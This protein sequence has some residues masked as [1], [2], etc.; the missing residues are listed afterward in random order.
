M[1]NCW[2][3]SVY[4][5]TEIARSYWT[6]S[7]RILTEREYDEIKATLM[8]EVRAKVESSQSNTDF[9]ASSEF[10]WGH[11]G[12][13]KEKI[14]ELAE[15]LRSI[16]GS[17]KVIFYCRD[18]ASYVSSAYAQWVKGPARTTKSFN[19]CK[20]WVLEYCRDFWDYYSTLSCWAEAFGEGNIKVNVFSRDSFYRG[21]L[22]ADFLKAVDDDLAE[23]ISVPTSQAD[24]I[25]PS[26][27]QIELIRYSNFIPGGHWRLDRLRQQLLTKILSTGISGLSN[28]K[29]RKFSEHELRQLYETNAL[30]NRRFLHNNQHVL[31]E[32]HFT[33]LCDHPN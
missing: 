12:A 7:H 21:D 6:K 24:N 27:L 19:S 4:G 8:E 31:P 33:P 23:K 30:F 9:I 25:S 13:E 1:G 29:T 22:I 20:R 17:V 5:D 2:K 10:I 32:V 15:A 28:N 3:L 14:Q 11:Y 26:N 16:F 18:Q